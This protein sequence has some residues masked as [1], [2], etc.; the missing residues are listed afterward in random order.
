MQSDDQVPAE[1]APV[2]LTSLE[3]APK[4]SGLL[5]QL[6]AAGRRYQRAAR[7]ESTWRA[8]RS[9]WADFVQWCSTHGSAPVPAAPETV[10]YYLTHLAETGLRVSTIRRRLAS[11]SVVH[12]TS[13]HASP[14]RDRLVRDQ[15]AGIARSIGVAQEV[16]TPALT[17]DVRSM[18]AAMDHS[19]HGLRDR[20]LI[21]VG[22]AAALRRSEIAALDVAD[23]RKVTEGIEV[24]IRRSKTDQIGAGEIVPVPYGSHHATCPVRAL[25][26]WMLA[27]DER[28][29][30]GPSPALFRSISRDGW[31]LDRMSG[32]AV[33]EVVARAAKRAGLD[34]KGQW[35]GHSLRAGLATSAAKAGVPDRVIMATTRHR[36]RTTLDRYVRSGT[37]WEQVAAASVG[38]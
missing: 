34:P 19:P 11:I 30:N 23:I 28:P 22:F 1:P 3:P 38:L 12:Q 17:E 6:D 16:A 37:R 27:L 4:P 13:G 31:L 32:Q 8:Y 15:M 33:G 20:A 9:D 21:L 35:T 5:A 10:A 26:E 7:S 36:S 18:V 14:T 29:S 2:L 24:C 25:D